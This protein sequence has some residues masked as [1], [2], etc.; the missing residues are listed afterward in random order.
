M[1]YLHQE[2]LQVKPSSRSVAIFTGLLLLLW[3]LLAG[4]GICLRAD[5]QPITSS[6]LNTQVSGPISL[7]SGQTQYNLTG[8]TRPGGGANLFHSFGEFNVPT[9][10]IA[11]FLNETALPTSNILGRVTAGNPSS[12]FGTIQTEGFGSAN[13]FLINPAG[14]LFGPGAQLNVGGNFYVSSADY[15][16]LQEIGGGNAGIFYAN[17]TQPSVLTS[18]PVTAFGFLGSNPGPITVQGSQL[19]IPS[20][21]GISLVGGNITVQA[22]ALEDGTVQPARLST[23]GGQINLASVASPGEVLYPSLQAGP[24]V[25]GQ[26]FTNMGTITLSEGSRLDVS[27]DAAGTVRIRG[28]QFVIADA[29]ISADTGDTN[30]AKTAVD[31][32]VT[33]DLSISNDTVP[34]V[35]ART[36]G[37]GDAGEIRIASANLNATS[38]APDINFILIDSHTSGTGKAGN[39]TLT[40]GDLQAAG[41]VIFIHSG[42]A[43]PGHGGDVTITGRSV[44][45]DKADI[46]S[47]DDVFREHFD[48]TGSGGTVKITADSLD[49]NNSAIFTSSFAARAG[50]VTLDARNINMRHSQIGVIS[51][52]GESTIAITADK[53][54]MDSISVIDASTALGQGGGVTVIANVVE[55]SN[56]SAIRTSTFGDGSAGDIIITATDHVSLMDDPLVIEATRA[57]G[58]YSN[59]FG[60]EG[61]GN[62]GNAGSI[63]VTTPQL[64]MAGGARMNTTTAS[65]G[66]GGDVT[67]TAR[68]LVSISGERSQEI[69]EGQSG[70]GSTRASGIYTRTVG[71][72]FCT[73]QCGDAGRISITTGSLTL[74]SGA[75]LDS[76][77]TNTGQGGAITIQSTGPVS[78]AGTM[79]DGTPGGI[80][81]RTIGME[82]DSGS[83]GNINLHTQQFA[84][85]NGAAISASGSGSGNAGSIGIEGLASPAGAVTLT[86]GSLLTSAENTGHGG[87][88]AIEATNLTLTDSRISASV[89]DFDNSPGST[90]RATVGLGDIGLTASVMSMIGGKITAGT[91]GSRN[92]GTIL[93]NAIVQ[94]GN[95]MPTAAQSVTLRNGASISASSSGPANAGNII[96]NAGQ[97][98]TSTNSSVTTQATANGTQASGGNMTLTAADMVHLVNSEISTSVQGGAATRGGD[99]TIDPQF[100]IL[101]NSQILATATQGNGGNINIVAGTFIADPA[102][103]VNASSQQGVS[104]TVNIQ[105][106][107]QNFSSVLAPLPKSFA[108]AAALL[109][110]RCA[111][112]VAGGQVSTFVMAGREGLPAEP[113]GFLTSPPY[114]TSATG[115]A[116]DEPVALTPTMLVAMADRAVSVRNGAIG[117]RFPGWDIGC[118]FQS[119]E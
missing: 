73:G 66:R 47:G 92:G 97:T 99:I 45:L 89:H 96:I 53:F 94:D 108:S 19:S 23:P 36:S 113:G 56:G 22:G 17:P 118:R 90:D 41:D 62:L 110:Q 100:V 107:V 85:V 4:P 119:A 72:E 11:N 27:G 69:E 48:V 32:N 49:L 40:T 95:I 84:L 1:R 65:S 8:G 30:G 31:I 14:V 86:N 35:T 18:A 63:V 103:V 105:S 67:I 111:A 3:V 12:I 2:A 60:D 13:L 28:G 82:P 59:A 77:T 52:E 44:K 38:A 26:S 68:D 101:Q 29:T 46:D 75:V 64:S 88:I 98:Y 115:V 78:I 24:N 61:L 7:P 9:N 109:A 80:F 51:L 71:S 42:T 5:A 20:G 57:S 112:R 81:S 83:G 25:N 116:G 104:G 106:P 74:G 55:L 114:R 87:T 70:L 39:V 43:G 102:S 91:S 10:N 16:R 6:G 50:D 117:D 79:T 93:V 54:V 15:L 37:S 21:Q 34:A 33:G 76:G 58:L